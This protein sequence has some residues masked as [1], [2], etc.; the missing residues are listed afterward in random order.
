M[1]RNWKGKGI[2]SYRLTGTQKMSKYWMAGYKKVGKW[3][4]LNG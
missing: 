3:K 2:D 1:I 4:L